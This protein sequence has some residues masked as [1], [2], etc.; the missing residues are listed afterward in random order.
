M[1]TETNI[2][3]SKFL[4]IKMKFEKTIQNIEIEKEVH[5]IHPKQSD[6]ANDIKTEDI[7]LSYSYPTTL[8][9]GYKKINDAKNKVSSKYLH[10]FKQID[11]IEKNKSEPRTRYDVVTV[12]DH[13]ILKKM[14]LK[15]IIDLS[16]KMFKTADM[17]SLKN[18]S[19]D[20]RGIKNFMFSEDFQRKTL[21]EIFNITFKSNESFFKSM[22][23]TFSK[24]SEHCPNPYIFDL[25]KELKGRQPQNY[26]IKLESKR[27]DF[28]NALHRLGN[29]QCVKF[30]FTYSVNDLINII[31]IYSREYLKGILQEPFYQYFEY[32][33]IEN[34]KEKYEMVL[35]YLPL[36]IK[37]ER[38]LLI[39]KLH[40]CINYYRIEPI[41]KL[42][43]VFIGPY[44]LIRSKQAYCFLID[45][46]LKDEYEKYDIV[47]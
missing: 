17:D 13:E 47:K 40:E 38:L 23:N 41:T 20:C 19:N 6:T 1:P 29:G 45:Y 37:P 11:E 18:S 31:M 39:R 24:K 7:I 10:L 34:D 32:F 36:L 28:T 26:E 43:N 3:K 12:S 22:L 42:S 8:K 33:Y 5:N 35:Q 2:S 44:T 46:I 4:S 16:V 30:L 15:K 25:F 27:E 9:N 14:N 21:S